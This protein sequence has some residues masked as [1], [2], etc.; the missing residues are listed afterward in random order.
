MRI[1]DSSV[2][3]DFLR[4][5]PRAV[6]LVRSLAVAGEPM[7]ASEI[8]RFEVLAGLRPNE[9]EPTESFLGELIW[10]PI[11]EQIARRA[12]A[13]A[14]VFRSSH[15]GIEDGDYLIAATALEADSALLTTNVR[16]FPMLSGLV[17]A[18]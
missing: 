10:L 5:E 9:E 16:H 6:D 18:Y 4:D 13:L 17:A 2:V 1:L 14:R 12:A 8:T 7:V 11:D 3:I 15:S